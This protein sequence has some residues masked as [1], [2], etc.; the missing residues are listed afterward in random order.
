M[1][2][3]LFT[4]Q[5]NVL[6]GQMIDQ[7]TRNSDNSAPSSLNYAPQ[8]YMEHSTTVLSLSIIH[9]CP[10]SSSIMVDISSS[11]F[12]CFRIITARTGHQKALEEVWLGTEYQG[13]SINWFAQTGWVDN[14]LPIYI[15]FDQVAARMIAPLS[16]RFQHTEPSTLPGL[17]F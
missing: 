7:S 10:S 5:T 2:E 12:T 6:K 15:S 11:E 9:P 4:Y 3:N 13:D 8:N 14:H 17:R 16:F 1:D